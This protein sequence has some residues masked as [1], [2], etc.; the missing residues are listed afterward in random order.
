MLV[1][2]REQKCQ[3]Q[4]IAVRQQVALCAR[5]ASV[6]RVGACGCAPL[7]P[8]WTRC[9]YKPGS[10]RCAVPVAGA[11]A[12]LGVSAAIRQILASRAVVA[13]TSRPSR[14]SSPGAAFPTGCPSA[15][16]KECQ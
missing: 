10:S 16:Q 8:G 6:R 14:I 4:A 3:R 2:A 7:L 5:F 11:A 15:V 1:G 13:S 9:P 12:A